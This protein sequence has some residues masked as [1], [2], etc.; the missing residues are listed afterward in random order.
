VLGAGT[1][2]LYASAVSGSIALLC[3]PVDNDFAISEDGQ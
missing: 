3:R 2:K 1:G